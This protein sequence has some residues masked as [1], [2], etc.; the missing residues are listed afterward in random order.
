MVPALGLGPLVRYFRAISTSLREGEGWLA[1]SSFVSGLGARSLKPALPLVS[2]NLG[3]E[4]P[5]PKAKENELSA[6]AARSSCW[7]SE[8]S[9]QRC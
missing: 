8:S 5:V 1:I 6:L 7:P 3:Q 2:P 4:V 9:W